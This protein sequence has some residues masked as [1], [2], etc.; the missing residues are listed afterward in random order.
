MAAAPRGPSELAWP[1]GRR[2]PGVRCAGPGVSE[3][4]SRCGPQ[5]TRRPGWTRAHS[6]PPAAGRAV[7][8]GVP[9]RR[10]AARCEPARREGAAAAAGAPGRGG[11]AS[12]RAGRPLCAISA[13][14]RPTLTRRGRASTGHTL[15]SAAAGAASREREAGDARRAAARPTAPAPAA[16]AGKCRPAGSGRLKPTCAAEP[17]VADSRA[18]PSR[19]LRSSPRKGF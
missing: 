18:R 7:G 16:V 6:Q 15:G 1:P 8:E 11:R 19:R 13:G 2:A 14:S 3:E 9:P 12:A 5:A 4:L 10:R 17:E